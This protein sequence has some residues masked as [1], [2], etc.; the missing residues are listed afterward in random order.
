MQTLPDDVWDSVVLRI[1]RHQVR[2]FVSEY[3]GNP[4]LLLSHHIGYGEYESETIMDY[5]EHVTE[6]KYDS[7]TYCLSFIQMA[8]LEQM[9]VDQVADQADKAEK[10]VTYSQ[11][12]RKTM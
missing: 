9:L 6:Y 1:E 2:M 4:E 5:V 8:D 11:S 10:F 12:L 7:D 3:M